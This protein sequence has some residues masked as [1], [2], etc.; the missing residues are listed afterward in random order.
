MISYIGGKKLHSKWIVP[1][2]PKSCQTYVEVFG[3]AF[4]I[5][6][7]SNIQSE[8]VVY[9]D[10]NPQLANLFSCVSNDSIKMLDH[11]LQYDPQDAK[12]FE[13]F[14]DD[15]FSKGQLIVP[16]MPDYDQASKF[17]YCQT[18]VFSGNTFSD[19]TKMTDLKGKYK[20][21]YEH[22]IDKLRNSH[23]VKKM[24]D[25][26]NVENRAFEDIINIYDSKDTF[27]YIDPPYYGL[28]S[29]Y[30]HSECNHSVL[31]NQLKG[32]RGKFALSYYNF[33]ELENILSKDKYNW[34]YKKVNKQNGN[35]KKI[36][37][38]KGTELLI[39]NYKVG[40]F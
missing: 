4:W 23:Y 5:H 29:Y 32:I 22:F 16:N 8:K 13:S 7:M 24:N 38:S 3:G 6:F 17:V 19:R 30:T 1:Q 40:L 20:S 25:I 12:L 11:C 28:E 15:L 2:L 26:T 27:F 35:R 36:N 9:N 37:S 39:T 18:Q 10:I 33:P 14:R 34:I 21:K 31:L